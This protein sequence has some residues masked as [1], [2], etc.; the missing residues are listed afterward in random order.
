MVSP[1]GYRGEN[2]VANIWAI[3]ERYR[4][5]SI[6][7]VPTIYSAL[8]SVPKQGYDL[9]S[10][11]Y[12]AVGAAPLSPELF[13]S[14]VGYSGVELVEG[15]GL[16]ECT[17]AASANPLEGEKKVGSIGLRI[18]FQDMR[19]AVLDESGEISRFCK[20]NEVGVIVLKGPNVFPGYYK[21]EESGLT[22]DGWLNTGDLGRE[23]EDGY[24]WLTGRAKDL[25]IRGGHNIDPG[26]IENTLE[27]HEAVA[28]AAAVGQ[29]D[30]Y[31][32]EL[33][34]AY[35]QLQPNKHISSS[36]L[37]SWAKSKIPER[38]AAP[39]HVE[40]MQFI[41]VTAVGKIHKPPLRMK[42][43][44]R[45]V[46]KILDDNGL[47][48]HVDVADRPGKGLV[49]KI[50]SNSESDVRQVLG[51]LAINIEISPFPH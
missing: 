1:L 34:V 45:V 24:F 29:P 50:K 30:S 23:D 5:T 26:M 19:C 2:V 49:V 13:K 39:V 14:F 48:A 25:I 11:R 47:A 18:P 15:Y 41:P 38:A 37:K 4:A 9:S 20:V 17:V 43:T 16:T 22:S 21:R 36:D 7:G 12:A 31:A 42:A 6:S 44:K 40:I 35:V 28:L 51:E 3:V 32:G 46:N 8:M 10:L 27:E 33:P